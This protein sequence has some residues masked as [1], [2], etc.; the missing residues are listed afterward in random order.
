MN[1][2]EVSAAFEEN[3]PSIEERLQAMRQVA[4]REYPVRAIMMPIIP[5]DGWQDA[6]RAFT[7][8]L[9]SSVPVQ[10]LTLGGICIYRSARELMERKMGTR[11]PVSE[12]LITR[13]P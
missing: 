6:Y 5:V 9:L 7:E 12:R 8:R 10:R 1:P 4:D 11:N 2:P 13:L 3:V